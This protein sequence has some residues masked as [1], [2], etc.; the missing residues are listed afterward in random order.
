MAAIDNE[1]IRFMAELWDNNSKLWF[2]ENRERYARELREPFKKLR[3]DLEIP[4]SMMLPDLPSPKISKIN[5]DIRFHKDKPPYKEHV[6]IKWPVGPAE[7]TAAIGRHGWSAGV[8]IHGDKSELEWWRTNL[9][10]HHDLW[11]RYAS[12]IKLRDIVL[13]HIGD[14]YKKPLF[15]DIPEDVFDLVQAKGIYI[16]PKATPKFKKSAVSG[17]LTQL[18]MVLPAL[19]FATVSSQQLPDELAKL[20]ESIVPPDNK[21]AKVWDSVR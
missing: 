6:W 9:Q 10:K 16:F 20:G 13:V 4:L 2:D 1:A 8:A 21:V 17:Y 18:A 5:S 3:D 11:A 7:L 12:A 14:S 15:E 19:L